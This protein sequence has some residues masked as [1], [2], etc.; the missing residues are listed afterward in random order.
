MSDVG[1]RLY[2]YIG[3]NAKLPGLPGVVL[4]ERMRPSPMLVQLRD[5]QPGQLPGFSLDRYELIDFDY[6]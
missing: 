6:A 2:I 4:P 5:F 1:H 3:I